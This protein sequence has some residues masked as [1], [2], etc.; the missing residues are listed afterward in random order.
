MLF[1]DPH[2]YRLA[3]DQWQ[4]ERLAFEAQEAKRLS[5]LRKRLAASPV[6][7]WFS[8]PAIGFAVVAGYAYGVGAGVVL[9][10]LEVGVLNY[11]SES[12]QRLELHRHRDELSPRAF[13]TP[14]PVF[15]QPAYQPPPRGQEQ[16]SSAPPP[17]R[18]EPPKAEPSGEIRV[19]SLRQAIEILGLPPKTSL[20]AAKA[21]Y[22]T[23]MAA[24]HPDKC[25]H[26]GPELRA[27]A[28]KKS[29]QFNLALQYI[30]THLQ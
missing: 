6:M 9:F 21:A 22:R 10:F 30:K 26:L 4:R 23:L 2:L 20:S 15:E 5:R 13:T 12:C 28:A 3:V 17:P 11:V 14:E 27:L 7:T 18:T 8:L 1:R 16:T 24:Y 19:T 25:T 29:L